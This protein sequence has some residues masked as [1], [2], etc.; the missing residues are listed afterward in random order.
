M[1]FSGIN[2]ELAFG[3]TTLGLT[4]CLAGSNLNDAINEAIFQCNGMDKGVAGT[5]TATLGF[6]AA[7]LETD[8]VKIN[9]FAPG[10]KDTIEWHPAGDTATYIEV[11]STEALILS[12]NIS[13]PVNGVCTMD[14]NMR[15]ND[16]AIAAAT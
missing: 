4:D 8:V 7:L 13:D 2:T 15:L 12:R 11:T 6:S 9:A 3:S 14:V 16:I 10:T 1:S 5:R